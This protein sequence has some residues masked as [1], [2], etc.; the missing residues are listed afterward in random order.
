MFETVHIRLNEQKPLQECIEVV[1]SL[2]KKFNSDY[3]FDYHFVD[4]SYQQKF[5]SLQKTLVI[6]NLFSLIVIFIACMGLLGLSTYMIETRTREIGIRKVFGGSVRAIT[7]MLC[8]H[9]LKPI[10]LSL[11]IFSPLGW[12]AMNWWLNFSEYRISLHPWLLLLTWL[13]I[14]VIALL[15]IGMQTLRAAHANPAESLKTE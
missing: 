8:L 14:L 7:Q 2:F 5:A 10:L 3:P 13:L 9:S 12:I 11:V 15:T 4:Q 1:G 6:T